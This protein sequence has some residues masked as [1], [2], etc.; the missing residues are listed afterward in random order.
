MAS[1]YSAATSVFKT[2]TDCTPSTKNNASCSRQTRPTA[3]MSD[4]NPGAKVTLDKVTARV[5][6]SIAL[7]IWSTGM[8]PSPADIT[9][10][11]TPN[12]RAACRH[13]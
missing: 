11:S 3:A 4:R 5:L 10:S 12:R 13:G 1:M 2:P 6:P 8:T 9:R 7:I